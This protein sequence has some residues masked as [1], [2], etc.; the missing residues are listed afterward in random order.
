MRAL[1]G[2]IIVAGALVGLGLTAIGYGIRFHGY[3]LD[4]I[5]AETNQLYG[6]PTL[7]LVLVLLAISA[8]I[9]L[10]IAFLGLAHHH[11]RRYHEMQ[12]HTPARDVH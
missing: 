1:C 6:V 10:G 11:E 7:T 9:G 3:P 8:G 12:R 5:N 4:S 2:A